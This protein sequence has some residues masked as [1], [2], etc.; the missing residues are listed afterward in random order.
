MSCKTVKEL[1]D[2]LKT[3]KNKSSVVKTYLDNGN[4]SREIKIVGNKNITVEQFTKMLE[5]KM[6]NAGT[7]SKPCDT[8]KFIPFIKIGSEFTFLHTKSIKE[9]KF[10][11]ILTLAE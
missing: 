6:L 10:N 7:G 8:L 4:C 5:M 2:F 11:V 3:V 1:V 9:S